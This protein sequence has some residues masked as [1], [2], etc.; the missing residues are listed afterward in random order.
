MPRGVSED[1]WRALYRGTRGSGALWRGTGASCGTRG[2]DG[3]G[4]CHIGFGAL[5]PALGSAGFDRGELGGGRTADPG[6]GADGG[7]TRG[8]CQPGEGVGRGRGGGRT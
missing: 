1:A 3:R 4:I 6:D 8:L 7:F 2:E 5:P